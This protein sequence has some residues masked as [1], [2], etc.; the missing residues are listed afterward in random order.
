MASSKPNKLAFLSMPAPAAYVAGLGRGAS[1]FTTRSDIG[2]AREGP[3]PEQIAEAQAR[4]GEEEEGGD[5]A[6]FQDP[7]N[8]VG[9]FAGGVYEADDEEA[10]R[11]WEA[12]DKRMDMRRKVRREARE[13]EELAKFR[14]ERPKLQQQFTDLK[15]GLSSVSDAEWENLP[16]VA[17]LTGKKR[18]LNTRER[19]YAVPDIVLLG[20]KDR[21]EVVNSVNDADQAGADTPGGMQSLVDIGAARDKVLSLKLDQVSGTATTSGLSSSIDPKGYLTSLDSQIHKTAAEIGDIKKARSLFESLIKSNPKHAPGWIAAATLE[22]H[23]GHMVKA[24]RLIKQGCEQCPKSEDVWLEAARLHT[25][26]DAKVILA[27]AVQHLSQSVRIWLTAADLEQDVQAR[28]RVLRK[29][30]EHIPNSVRLWKETVNLEGNPADARVLLARAVELI[31]SSVELW[32]ALARLETPAKARQVINRA[33]L[34]VPTSHEVWIAACRLMEQEGE[35]QAAVDRMMAQA[36]LRLRNAGLVLKRDMWLDEADKAEAEGAPRTCVAIVRATVALEVEEEERYDRWLEDVEAFLEKGRVECARA[37]LAYALKVFP[38][39]P[40]LWRR[41]ADLEKEHGTRQ[42]L[43]QILAEAVRYCPQ[44]EVLWLM[45]AKEKWLAGDVPT[46]RRVL[47]DAFA[48]NPRSERIWLAAVKLEA[49]NGEVDVA[50]Q[51]LEKARAEADTERIW[52]KS[53][54]FERQ[55]GNTQRALEIVDAA[56]RKY[57]TFDKL[58]MIK[59]QIYADDLGKIKE[60][61]ETYEQGRKKCSKSIPLWILSSML[62]ERAGITIK[63]RSILDRARLVNPKNAELWAESIRI[64]ERAN[65]QGQAKTLLAKAL[66]ECPSSGLL[67]SMAIWAEPRASRKRVSVDAI[68]KCNDDPQVILSV[69]RMFYYDRS[70]MKARQWFERAVTA[71]PDLGDAWAWYVKFARQYGTEG[72]SNPEAIERCKPESIVQRTIT[73]EPHHGSVWQS[74]AKGMKNARKNTAEILELAVASLD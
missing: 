11:I 71:S 44:A 49:E 34:A 5:E 30:L 1:G 27:E 60:A 36:V 6:Q 61:R 50:R 73:A 24:R 38:D 46:A 16:E 15:R 67:W 68:K 21:N 43:E 56:L 51:V 33:R 12:V 18:K 25:P 22:E 32:L 69:A 42:A 8:E 28:K 14:S 29:A 64:E 19:T 20:N 39:R 7:D 13:A 31:P 45:A 35:E 48:A 54:V 26:A 63:A 9:L 23:A 66:Q 74:I 4:R 57:D 3:T 70:I 72:E 53:A 10:D 2:P 55:N 41:A 65:L 47:A 17:N 40:S 59:G 52:M 37:V 58:Y 62:E